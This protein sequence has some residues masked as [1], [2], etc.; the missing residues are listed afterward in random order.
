M[1]YFFRVH[2]RKAFFLEN[3]VNSSMVHMYIYILYTPNLGLVITVFDFGRER[4]RFR[5]STGGAPSEHG[6]AERARREQREHEGSF[7]Y[8]KMH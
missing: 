2:V 7:I 5:G 6:E 4:G 8:R 1:I 3:L